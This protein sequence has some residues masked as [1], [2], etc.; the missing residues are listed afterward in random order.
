MSSGFAT[1]AAP[2]ASSAAALGIGRTA[3]TPQPVPPLAQP[4]APV[5]ANLPV[6]SPNAQVATGYSATPAVQVP[7]ASGLAAAPAA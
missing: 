2:I 7:A 5:V 1:T 3:A 6:N 4:A